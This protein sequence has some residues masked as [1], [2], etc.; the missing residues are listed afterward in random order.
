MKSGTNRERKGETLESENARLGQHIDSVFKKRELEQ[1]YWGSDSNN[2]ST[3][4]TTTTTKAATTATRK[5]FT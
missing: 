3:K 2:K 1:A 5:H 4:A